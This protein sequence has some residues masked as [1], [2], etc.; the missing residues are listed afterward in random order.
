MRFPL[1]RLIES[2]FWIFLLIGSA[3]TLISYAVFGVSYKVI[4][5]SY[6][7]SLSVAYLLGIVVSY[8]SHRHVT[9]KS[10]LGHREAFS[11]FLII[12]LLIFVNTV[13]LTALTES[14]AMD[15][16]LGQAICILLLTVLGFISQSM[17]VFKL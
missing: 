6:T 7:L 13:L 14:W 9:F 3:N 1:N 4:D 5:L 12:Y 16:L 11:R 15:P 2:R 8:S 17:W 10:K